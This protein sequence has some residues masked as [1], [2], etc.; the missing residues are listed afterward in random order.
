MTDT[1]HAF[2]ENSRRAFSTP[3]RV[4]IGVQ[5]LLALGFGIFGILDATDP[6]W[7]ALQ[8]VVI[9]MMVGIWL[10]GIAGMVLIARLVSHKVAR[11]AILVAAP[12]AGFLLIAGWVM[13]ASG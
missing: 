13:V 2:I 4:I 1:E 5:V 6:D 12:L 7:G 3:E 8:R 9:F 10:A 11:V